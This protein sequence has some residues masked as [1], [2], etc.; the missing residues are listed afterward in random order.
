[1]FIKP[2][3]IVF[4][5]AYHPFI[6]GAEIAIS[7]VAK[8]LSNRFDFLI[9]TSRFR[10]ELPKKEIRPEG[11]IVRFGIGTPLDK[12]WLI[13]AQF[14]YRGLASIV[15]GVD[16][17]HGSIAAA[18][19]K[20]L[21]PSV[22]F[23]LN[24]QFGESEERLSHGRFGIISLMFRFI[25][26]R[27]DYVT[28]I[29]SYLLNLARR[30]GYNEPG[31]VIHNGVDVKNFQSPISNFQKNL[32]QKIIIT[33]SRLVYKNGIDTLIKA[34]AEVK[35]EI[36]DIQC[37]IIGDGPERTSYQ[38]LVTSNRLETNVKFFG[39]VPHDEISKYLHGADVF[40]R[41][42]RSEGMGNSFVEALAAGLPIIGTPVG[43]ITDIIEDGK[44]GFFAKPD[45]ADDLAQKIIYVL[46]HPED[47]KQTIEGGRKM[48]EESFSW[49]KI[50]A[51]YGE[52]FSRFV[53]HRVLNILI[54]TPLYP[55]QLGGPALYA[56][57]FGDKFRASGMRV[58]VVSFGDV[59]SLPTLVRH[60]VY[61]LKFAR[62][63]FFADIIMGLDSFSAGFPAALAS[64]LFRIPFV[65]RVEGD[66]LWESFV[67]RTQREVTLP[68]FYAN[69]QALTHKERIIR[70]TIGWV[71]RRADRLVFSSKWRREMI[72]QAFGIDRQKTVIIRNVWPSQ[73]VTSNQLPVTKVILW[74]GR[75]LYLKNLYR[76]IRAF[77]AA[78]AG[79]Y[80]LKL[81]GDG[82]EKT[83]VE[84][85]VKEKGFMGIT[86]APPAR[87]DDLLQEMS[88]VSFLVLPSFSDVGPNVI[89]EAYS[90]GTPFLFTKN[91][92]YTEYIADSSFW[93]DSLNDDE[94]VRK[95]K[96]LMDE[97][98]RAA[99]REKLRKT[100]I[101][102]SWED[103]AQ[104]WIDLFKKIAK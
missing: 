13:L 87:H 104:E 14:Y 66:F 51:S 74:V 46:R 69:F 81:I 80:E 103:A 17:S 41:P 57:N 38:L 3:I 25:L 78:N 76:L 50:A 54:A 88:G 23:I 16:I 12:Y 65:L 92:G 5:T 4:S 18:I 40:V 53:Q 47:A 58:S 68:D 55:P 67:E 37:H 71:M 63:C 43:G 70:A 64:V 73:A 91:S 75:M 34:V 15:I 90:G 72:I 24:I 1:M 30:Y 39:S 8:R 95:L 42:S 99:Q 22:P 102:H 96:W 31:E 45:D 33:T 28:A 77:S 97:R 2:K 56:K 86:F 11:T 93:V 82:P 7:E 59:L 83:R 61:F 6:G 19:Y 27:A 62:K 100:H 10:R 9:F 89:A 20:L 85:F 29:S 79:G 36:P 21:H 26:G 32:K 52:I 101:V 44:T 60:F 35:K 94:L 98:N 49:D 84:K 48:V